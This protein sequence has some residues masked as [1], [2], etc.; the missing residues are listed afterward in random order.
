MNTTIFNQTLLKK[1]YDIEIDLS[2][3][4]YRES[5]NRRRNLLLKWVEIID[6]KTINTLSEVQLKSDFVNDILCGVLNYRSLTNINNKDEWTLLTEQKTKTDATKADVVLG[7]FTK[8]LKDFRVAIELKG[9]DENLDSKQTRKD[10]K[11]TPVE[12]GFSYL[13]KYGKKCKWLIVSNYKEI[14]LYS[15]ADATEYEV[16]FLK[17]FIKSEDEL[18]RFIYLLSAKMLI[19]KD[20][21]SNV[22]LLWEE[23]I[24][25]QKKIESDFYDLY[26]N[27]R[28]TLFYDILNN[29]KHLDG[30]VILK[31]TQKLLD[32]FIF[33]CFAEDKGLIPE[34]IF[35]KVVE[36]GKQSFSKNGIWEQIKGLCEAIDKGNEEQGINQFNGG[37]FAYD[38]VLNNLNIPNKCFEEMELLSNY[39]FNS[40]L[41]EN[42]LGHIFEQSLS[43]LEEIKAQIDG[44]E[45]DI[46]KG[47]RKKDGIFY[48]PKYITKYIVE[49]TIG[50][51]L[52]QKRI[53]LGEHLLPELK[54][55]DYIVKVSKRGKY[56]KKYTDNMQ[57]HINFYIQ[58]KEIIT[59]IKVLDPACGSGAF[60]NAAFDYLQKVG[61]DVNNKLYDLTDEYTF[62]DW[63]V[64][65]LKN[66]L[67]GVDLNEESVEITRLSLWL[68]T[69]NKYNKLTSLDNNIKVGNS[70]IDNSEIE[71]DNYFDWDIEFP[72]VMK[73]GGFD[74]IIGNPPYVSTKSI[75]ERHREYYWLKYK[76]LLI[77]E[78][79]LYELFLYEFLKRKLK[80]GG[81]LGYI[82]PNTYYTNKSFSNLRNSILNDYRVKTII[83]FP[84]RYFPF[85][86]VNKET[87]IIIIENKKYDDYDIDLISIDKECMINLKSFNIQTYK[88]HSNVLKSNIEKYLDSKIVINF[89]NTIVNILNQSNKLGDYLDLHKGWMSIPDKTICNDIEYNKKIFTKEDI[90]ENPNLRDILVPCL[91]GKDIHRYYIDEVDK[92]VNANDMDLKTR[93]WHNAPKIIT[94]RIVGQNKVKIV[95][96]VDLENKVIFPNAN[97][98]NLKRDTDDIIMY[99]PIINSKLI[100]YFYNNFY[101]ESNTNITKEGFENIPVPNLNLNESDKKLFIEYGKC[102]LELNKINR[103]LITKFLKTIERAYELKDFKYSTMS[104]FYELEYS[105]FLKKLLKKNKLT[106]IQQDELEDYFD[107]YKNNINQNINEINNIELKIDNLVYKIYRLN[108]ND[109]KQIEKS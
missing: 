54:Q 63:N 62:F 79:D 20:G 105:D 10:D 109:I 103:G 77:S 85:E 93:D 101:G 86:D 4:K 46:K 106:L 13:P 11:R 39:D 60:L 82:T 72:E 107:K 9:P 47:K 31:K 95:T 42:I 16:F 21:K 51:Y 64:E 100:N 102:V 26:K 56:K 15:S 53:E 87:A 5:F 19:K 69:A 40:D 88:S 49:N 73:N 92:L 37:L 80:N 24:K 66:N 78:M 67:Y 1:K 45:F 14:R 12:Q 3:E 32:R 65:I 36:L 27:T 98:I 48:T 22:D 108:E 41:N 2:N 59:N 104:K 70:L 74:V 75:P 43:D 50:N 34:N 8:T 97:L 38:E 81:I 35:K 57:K 99:L 68:K 91:E 96:T 52:E 90:N 71:P 30:K 29:N 94:Q 25:E 55:E 23:N 33:I 6:N 76:E 61:N 83:D 58:Y 17:D 18:K 84:Y 7:Y 89:N 44:I 28:S